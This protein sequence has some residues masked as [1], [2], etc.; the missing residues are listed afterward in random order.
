MGRRRRQGGQKFWYK[1]ELPNFLTLA[2]GLRLDW[3]DVGWACLS[4]CNFGQVN[5]ERERERKEPDP[6]FGSMRVAVSIQRERKGTPSH[7]GT[8]RFFELA[9]VRLRLSPFARVTPFA[10]QAIRGRCQPHA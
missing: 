3:L 6:Q 5:T 1:E 10:V 4:S 2:S 8:N 9:V 7:A